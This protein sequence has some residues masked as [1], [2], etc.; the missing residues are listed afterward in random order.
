[1]VLGEHRL[2]GSMYGANE[3]T[4]VPIEGQ[5]NYAGDI[6]AL[7]TQ[8]PEELR[9][10]PRQAAPREAKP[11][12]DASDVGDG[13]KEGAFFVKG[14]KVYR[15]DGGVGKD[16]GLKGADVE[17]IKQL[18]GIRDLVNKLLASQASGKTAG[19]DAVRKELKKL[20][21][22][23]VK[24]FGPIN[25]QQDTVTTRLNKQGENIILSKM[26]NFNAFRNDPDAYKVA[27]I[28]VY[29]AESQ[30]AMPSAIM[31]RDV[32]GAPRER[33]VESPADAIA[34]SLEARGFLDEPWIAGA[35]KIPV[36][37]VESRLGDLAFRDPDGDRL[38][39]RDE[40]L[41]G[42]V[43]GKLENAEA[44]LRENPSLQRNVDELRKVQP[45]PLT[46]DEIMVQFGAPWVP[47]DVYQ[48]FATQALGG[49]GIEIKR[50]TLTAEWVISVKGGFAGDA[51][52]KFSTDRVGLE[53]VLKAAMNLKR[54]SV[55]DKTADGS[56]VL[57]AEATRQA[58]IKLDELRDF[59]SGNEETGTDAW[60]WGDGERRQR[61][62]AIYNRQFNSKVG[63]QYDGSHLTFPGMASTL[64]GADGKPVPFS[65]RPH[66]K[67][68]VWRALQ[69]GNTLY[70]HV[71]G[72]GKT[73]TMIAAGMEG[74]RLGIYR[75]PMY[76][77]PNHM[78]EQFSREFL[79]AYPGAKILV[80]Q[81]DEMTKDARRGFAAKAS[82][83]DWDA[84]II[85]HDAFGRIQ[86]SPDWQA[87]YIARQVAQIEDLI[88]EMKG[89]K[90][91]DK[92]TVKQIENAKLKMQARVEALLNAE[93]KDVGVT[94]EELGVDHIFLDEA[95]LFKNLS[96]VTKMTRVKGLSQGN[97]QRAE[98]L[99][100]KIKWLE[101]S[102]PGRS[103]VFATGTPISNTIAEMFTMQRYLQEPLLAQMGLDKFDSWAATF[104]Q[105]QENTELS[106]D[107]RTTKTVTSFSRFVNIPELVAM[108]AEIADTQTADMLNLPRPELGRNARGE[109]GIIAVK[110]T[111]SPQEESLI[112][113]F[114]VRAQNMKGPVVKGGDNML[115]VVTDGRKVATDGRLYDPTLPFNPDGKLAKASENILKH[116]R[117]GKEPALA[118]LVFLD[119]GTPKAP[120]A[121]KKAAPAA[122]DPDDMGFDLEGD[123]DPAQEASRVNLYEELRQML[124]ERGIPRA[125]IAFIHEATDD[126]KKGQLFEKV[127]RGEVRVLVGSTGKMGVGTNVQRR[128]IAMHHIDAPYKP[129]EVEQRD[130][131]GVRQGNMNKEIFIYRYVTERSFDAFMWQKLDTKSRFIAQLKSGAKG[132][133]VAEDI[134]NPLPEAAEM[135]AAASGDPRIMEEA[136]LKRALTKLEA[137]RRSHNR[138]QAD[139]EWR[140]KSLENTIATETAAIPK[141]KARASK[142]V[143]VTGDK[144]SI[145]L[146]A[147]GGKAG[148]TDKTEAG[149]VLKAFLLSEQARFGG[150]DGDVR[151]GNYAGFELHANVTRKWMDAGPVNQ[152][153][154]FLKTPDG[155]TF[156]ARQAIYV[157]DAS[158]LSGVS[159]RL[160]TMA[161][162][163]QH[164]PSIMDARLVK[165]RVELERIKAEPKKDFP[166]QA[167]Y[168]K[169]LARWKEISE[170]LKPKDP[171]K[172]ETP[173]EPAA[174]MERVTPRFRDDFDRIREEVRRIV[175]RIA[176]NHANGFMSV[177]GG[178]DLDPRAIERSGGKAGEKAR[179]S[180]NIALRIIKVAIGT[181]AER[182]SAYHEAFHALEY[183]RAFSPAEMDLF[184]REMPRLRKL[185][186]QVYGQTDAA[187]NKVTDDEVRAYA[188]EDY[189]HRMDKRSTNPVHVGIRR[190]FER[191]LE[192]LRQV[193]AMLNGR[194]YRTA[195]DIFKDVYSGEVGARPAT[196]PGAM[197][198]ATEMIRSLGLEQQFGMDRAATMRRNAQGER[199]YFGDVGKRQ[200][201]TWDE[202]RVTAIENLVDYSV[203]A[204][205]LQQE[206][207]QRAGPLNQ[208]RRGYDAKRVMKSKTRTEAQNYR[209][210]FVDPLGA[211]LKRERLTMQDL[212]NYL[213]ARHA[214]E[215][216]A[217]MDAIDP[218]NAGEGSGI[219]DAEAANI[220]ARL[221]REGKLPGLQRVEPLFRAMAAENL[222]R[223]VR[224]SLI[225]V[226]QAETWEA[227]YSHY[228][229]LSG[230]EDA[231]LA[232]DDAF[233]NEAQKTS[234]RNG[235]VKQALGRRGSIS[236][237][238]TANLIRQGYRTIERTERN[239]VFMTFWRMLRGLDPG[240]LADM[241]I[242]L[243]EGDMV[244]VFDAKAGVVQW[245]EKSPTAN[246]ARVVSG[247]IGGQPH[248]I[249]F[250]DERR[251]D[252]IN[253]MSPTEVNR[254]FAH[255][256]SVINTMK[257]LW[258]YYNPEFL[259]RHFVFRN[260]LE[261]MVNSSE[262]GL[263]AMK[264]IN[265]GLPFGP[266]MRAIR[267]THGMKEAE[268]NA[269]RAAFLS[270]TATEQ[271]KWQ[272]YYLEAR[273]AGAI[274]D[275][276]S[277]SDLA[278]IKRDMDSAVEQFSANP[279]KMARRFA[280]A[281]HK[282]FGR[283]LE[284][285][286][287][288]GRI[289]AYREARE[290]G[291]D[292]TASALIA[293]D[294][295]TDFELRGKM[296]NSINLIWPFQNTSAGG[297]YRMARGLKRSKALRYAV[298]GLGVLGFMTELANYLLGGDDEDG[299]PWAENI[300]LRV[301]RLHATV[302]TPFHWDGQKEP[303]TVK[304]PLPYGFAQ[305]YNVG[306]V[307]AWG[308]MKAL[309]V[310]KK[311]S[312]GDMAGFMMDSVLEGWTG[313]PQEDSLGGKVVPVLL[314]PAWHVA[315]NE[316]FYGGPLRTPFPEK[317]VARSAQGGERVPEVWKWLATSLNK[318]TG[319]NEGQSGLI[320][321]YPEELR[322]L[323]GV[324]TSGFER[325][326]VRSVATSNAIEDGKRPNPEDLP[327]GN[328]LLMGKKTYDAKSRAEYMEQKKKALAVADA[329][330]KQQKIN[331]ELAQRIAAENP[332]AMAAASVIRSI[333]RELLK[334]YKQRDAVL[335]DE[336]MTGSRRRTLIESLDVHIQSLRDAGNKA[337]AQMKK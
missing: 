272:H 189:A 305:F 320:D 247:K 2:T 248:H 184:D 54:L 168:E 84:I 25:L 67:N 33:K 122:P 325:M 91:S 327:I 219:S 283:Q 331:P 157:D 291:N 56:S 139:L 303:L 284:A 113:S 1:M 181:G 249:V 278:S 216:N 299:V 66:Q 225:S 137:Q 101:Q 301:K 136:N 18:V 86:M 57:N 242:K 49:T 267:A 316:T 75:K 230:F 123:A 239:R 223:M 160:N 330:K 186:Q 297:A 74:R 94:F 232:P 322:E 261:S 262:F 154:F 207:E 336:T 8:F 295:T 282:A 34:S 140:Q 273:A 199:I 206:V 229:P 227:Q 37:A 144:F 71:V 285:L 77:V 145:D 73:F 12:V 251:A 287:N 9:M 177:D 324:M 309:G 224:G 81:K 313:L 259:V 209:E 117:E 318:W 188:F 173:A 175:I 39:P 269:V 279:L 60:V 24:K 43:V 319:G 231:S 202:K 23:F 277:M 337:I 179:G 45:T 99:Y 254:F 163:I 58:N 16:A 95:H 118:Q 89:D 243:D 135:K 192:I 40:Y 268:R 156:K 147:A 17:K 187:M 191:V 78:L 257:G 51:R 27:A 222:R 98:D 76:A 119:M 110:S 46:S 112:D 304:I 141:A 55:F 142:L 126:R 174:T 47:A 158:D 164:A 104:G 44:A 116:Y 317:G 143:D 263:G 194:G 83:G 321:R 218:T 323:L 213:F 63:R 70:D 212:D 31:E 215:R 201:T 198:S 182:D 138:T 53:E 176:G 151:L 281:T 133:R 203:M 96:F 204:E 52:A 128:L 88:L 32:V 210:K 26:P 270:G 208:T 109:R 300:E 308:L 4:V 20:H 314:L 292:V 329:V 245:K 260:P 170:A 264:R 274:V 197:R 307:A 205:R 97:S 211:A 334:I 166:R 14:G 275:F 28:E 148:I 6:A 311:H 152:V 153:L 92:R 221:T 178:I 246:M 200:G 19:N 87:Q 35:L 30:T 36:E 11:D 155:E 61:L 129:A 68:A 127:R 244:R 130:G 72:A 64:M 306:Q 234:V 193:R 196:G 90:A 5:T 69:K 335:K 302:V 59:F 115:K 150:R 240:D 149:N 190:A 131:R 15:K 50:N 169:T 265:R 290:Q 100:L 65:L 217:A 241:G 332:E 288:A 220:I 228:A 276:N 82:T 48:L 214:P 298:G 237:S 250:D 252:A 93:R 7:A 102:R 256:N 195:E 162:D 41:S 146:Q 29:D 106:A 326:A 3:Y 226:E 253:R 236:G 121:A 238:P 161:A 125:E 13:I 107:G 315:I 10:Q 159:S 80:A 165:T 294:L 258:T 328:I 289:A 280:S 79:Q 293:R 233:F 38:V 120:Q 171:A 235:E 172:P 21:A 111:P 108:Y 167:E 124:V 62:A 134:D 180:F 103:A 105:M 85:T 22:A 255:I 333:D 114:V 132:V 312:I 286:D 266:A 185:V 271:Q 296:A 310:S 42:D 183:G